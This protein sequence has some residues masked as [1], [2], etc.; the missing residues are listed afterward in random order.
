MVF[1]ISGIPD[2]FQIDSLVLRMWVGGWGHDVS[3]SE[4]ETEDDEYAYFRA[5]QAFPNEPT[6]LV[7]EDFDSGLGQALGSD[8]V[9]LSALPY[10]GEV[11]V[12]LYAALNGSVQNGGYLVLTI[13]GGHELEAAGFGDKSHGHW[14]YAEGA[15]SGQPPTLVVTGTSACGNGTPEIGEECEDGNTADDDGCTHDC[16]AESVQIIGQQKCITALNKSATQLATTQGKVNVRCIKNTGKGKGQP[17]CAGGVNVGL[18]CAT[19]GDCQGYACE[20]DPQACL[21]ADLAGKVGKTRAK[22]TKAEEKSCIDLPNFGYAGSGTVNSAVVAQ[23]IALAADVFGGDLKS[24]IVVKSEDKAGAKCQAKVAKSYENL[25]AA[26]LRSFT[27]C[28]Q[29]W[30]K[31]EEVKSSTKLADCLCDEDD[32]A[33]CTSDQDPNAKIAGALAKLEK[34]INKKCSGVLGGGVGA[35]V[36][37]NGLCLNGYDGSVAV[38]HDPSLSVT[39]DLTI[40]A[41][42]KLPPGPRAHSIV[43]KTH[44]GGADTTYA[45]SVIPF[46]NP[47]PGPGEAAYTSDI[48]VL[49]YNDDEGEVVWAQ[50]AHTGET[51]LFIADSTWHHVAVTRVV[52]VGLTSVL[53]YLD[54]VLDNDVNLMIEQ[55]V[56]AEN[57]QSVMIGDDG[58]G[59]TNFDGTIDEVRISDI[60]RDP[61]AFCLNSAC[62]SDVNTVGLWHLDDIADGLATDSSPNG[63]DGTV[64]GSGCSVFGGKC[65]SAVVG[66]LGTCVNDL[67]DCRVC[68]TL[69]AVDGLSLDCDQFDDGEMNGSCIE[70]GPGYTGSIG[71][72]G[73]FR[74]PAFQFDNAGELVWPSSLDAYQLVYGRT[75]EGNYGKITPVSDTP[76]AIAPLVCDQLPA[77]VGG[78]N[79]GSACSSDADCGAG[80]CTVPHATCPGGKITDVVG[81]TFGTVLLWHPVDLPYQIEVSPTEPSGTGD[82]QDAVTGQFASST[83]KANKVY[84]DAL[85]AFHVFSSGQGN[86]WLRMYP[87]PPGS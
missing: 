82:W 72:I 54:G 46:I 8:K 3:G 55:E 18:P 19:S 1:P 58:L 69:K 50:S 40:E 9:Y 14:F 20:D 66:T 43:T 67:T 86:F 59:G 51:A 30:L 53:F 2:G 45:F 6:G 17:F 56:A 71:E 68:L 47:E 31:A 80:I 21:G 12:P 62:S 38:E 34:G 11:E 32:P 26:K 39:G 15:S 49:T 44:P 5:Q 77:C 25:V 42:V 10:G 41:W 75:Y 63:N 81:F 76:T 22:V 24:A 64:I 23:E 29:G 7:K 27:K 78:A 16:R 48:L 52:G 35:G 74:N 73:I 85:H 33:N 65:K 61:S 4:G 28:K 83:L 79:E 13:R 70:E 87:L 37:G 60:A 36:Y 84:K 57:T